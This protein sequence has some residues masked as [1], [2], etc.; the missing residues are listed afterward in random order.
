MVPVSLMP[1]ALGLAAGAVAAAL[2][3]G[4][5][6]RDAALAWR[7]RATAAEQAASTARAAAVANAAAAI[8][9]RDAASVAQDRVAALEA[10]R[11]EIRTRVVTV[12]REVRR[13][14]DAYRPVGPA[15][16]RAALRL[17]ELDAAH[18]DGAGADPAGPPVGP[19]GGAGTPAAPR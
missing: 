13:E 1:A 16:R 10:A 19:A 3:W 12:T 4:W 5:V 11:G 7:E 9:Q 8:W 18:R 17:R 15:L 14:P 6:E 2:A